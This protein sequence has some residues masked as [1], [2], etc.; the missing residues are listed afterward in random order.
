MALHRRYNETCVLKFDSARLNALQ[1]MFVFAVDE[2]LQCVINGGMR[3]QGAAY[4]EAC[5]KGTSR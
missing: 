2:M 3:A 4:I 1:C 5:G